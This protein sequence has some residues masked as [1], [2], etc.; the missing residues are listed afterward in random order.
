MCYSQKDMT[1]LRRHLVGIASLWLCAQFALFSATGVSLFEGA[2]AARREAVSCTC[3][4]G[5]DAHC[6][7]HHHGGSAPDY[8]CHSNTPDPSTASVVALLGPIAVLTATA[9]SPISST[10]TSVFARTAVDVT[11][12]FAIPD[13]PPPRS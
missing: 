12:W 7:M 2:S 13:G 10:S 6:P 8:R 11:R 4:H 3:I 5:A 1:S 9:D